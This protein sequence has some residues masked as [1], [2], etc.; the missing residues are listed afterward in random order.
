MPAW[1]LGRYIGLI[2]YTGPIEGLCRV[3]CVCLDNPPAQNMPAA[4]LYSPPALRYR[5]LNCLGFAS[6]GV[7]LIQQEVLGSPG[8]SSDSEGKPL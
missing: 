5:C 7:F 4:R 2:Y 1:V 3:S 6:P 8:R